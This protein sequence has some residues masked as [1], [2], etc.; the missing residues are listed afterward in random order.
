MSSPRR[1]LAPPL[2]LL[3]AGAALCL[4]GCLTPPPLPTAQAQPTPQAPSTASSAA[5]TPAATSTPVA[6]GDLPEL[7]AINTPLAPGTLAGWE[8]SILTDEAFE[9]QADS[10]FPAGPTISVVET[11]TGCTFWAYQGT[12]DSESTDEAVSSAATLAIVSSSSPDDWEPD[13]VELEPSASQGIAVE[14]LSIVQEHDDGGAEAWFARNFQSSGSTSSI[15]A[16]CP[17]GAGGVEHIDEVVLEHFHVNF[18]QP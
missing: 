3:A 8:T 1:R 12:Q 5:P 4:S 2:V 11:A 14:F 9:P 7:V 10:D 16:S 18:L 6:D 17:A 15:V 13:V